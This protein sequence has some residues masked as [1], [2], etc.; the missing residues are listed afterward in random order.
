MGQALMV[1]DEDDD[2]DDKDDD[3]EDEGEEW[4]SNQAVSMQ[5]L[6]D[7]QLRVGPRWNFSS[8]T[9]IDLGD[10]HAGGYDDHGDGD[11]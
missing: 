8:C 1:K 6:I 5:S 9:I 3:D 10:D 4:I 7:S 2:D 11:D